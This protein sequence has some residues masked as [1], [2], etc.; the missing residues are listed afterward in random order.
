[1][2]LGLGL[3]RGGGLFCGAWVLCGI[4]VEGFAGFGGGLEL[5]LLKGLFWG[6]G[7]LNSCL[8]GSLAFFCCS[9]L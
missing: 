7:L 1:M 8:K 2:G 9:T 4:G 5:P 3:V 6:G